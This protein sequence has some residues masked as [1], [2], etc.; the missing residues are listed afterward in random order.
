MK[1]P[2]S[3]DDAVVGLC[4]LDGVPLRF[5]SRAGDD[6]SLDPR[7]TRLLDRMGELAW[8]DADADAPA[9]PS[10]YDFGPDPYARY[11]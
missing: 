6:E 3:G 4:S 5:R 11:R 7:M 1:R 2:K 8:I 9:I 10:R